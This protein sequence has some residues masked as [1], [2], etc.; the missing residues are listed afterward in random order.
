[1]LREDVP[2]REIAHA[3]AAVLP[4]DEE[5]VHPEVTARN[6]HLPV[7]ETKS[8]ILPIDEKDVRPAVRRRPVAIQGIAVLPVQV[9]VLVPD[10]RQVVLV[11]LEHAEHG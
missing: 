1:M 3:H 7:D 8:S 4:D 9:Q 11:Q 10:V 6:L 5:L 2:R